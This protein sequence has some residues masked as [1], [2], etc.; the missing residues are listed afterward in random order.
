ME[1]I[2]ILRIPTPSNKQCA[3]TT[4][5][6]AQTGG[7]YV[8]TAGLSLWVCKGAVSSFP[9]HPARSHRRAVEIFE[10]SRACLIFFVALASAEEAAGVSLFEGSGDGGAL[11]LASPHCAL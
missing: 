3:T 11:D 6:S 4:D 7:S 2:S 1:A 9:G 5:T 8:P 10:I